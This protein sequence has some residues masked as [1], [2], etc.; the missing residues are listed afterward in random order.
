MHFE[1]D[2]LILIG[3]AALGTGTSLAVLIWHAHKGRPITLFAT[4]IALIVLEWGGGL[5]KSA[6]GESSLQLPDCW[7][8]L[9]V[10]LASLGPF[11]AGYIV[12]AVMLHWRSGPLAAREIAE[13]LHDRVDR[14]V[15]ARLWVL[16][17]AL[18]LCTLY[19]LYVKVRLA[20]G[21]RAFFDIAYSIR[22]GTHG[23][24]G[25]E[26]MMIVAAGLLAG[27]VMAVI[28]LLTMVAAGSTRLSLRFWLLLG[29]AI[30]LN[31]AISAMHGRR[32][33]V[34]I[35]TVIPLMAW[36]LQ[37]PIALRA[38]MRISCFLLLGLLCLN[39]LHYYRFSTTADW[40]PTS[41]TESSMMLLTPQEH[42]ET[43]AE[44]LN[45]AEHSQLL[46]A[47]QYAHST[48]SLV[49]RALWLD[50]PEHL[51]SLAVQGWA[52]LPTHFQ[53]SVTDVGEAVACMGY[54]GMAA[55]AIWGILYSMLDCLMYSSAIGRAVVVGICIT[56]VCVDQ[57]MGVSALS[58]S[59]ICAAI[60]TLLLWV[61]VPRRL[62]SPV[63]PSVN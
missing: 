32:V 45:T 5:I 4:Y 49:P 14:S 48:A 8:P 33:G 34:I 17:A 29:A 60:A 9:I 63:A 22:F 1:S 3:L 38:L 44:V 23:E 35:V 59:M 39:W 25:P 11:C 2:F 57:G 43:L 51:G 47:T 37:R 58:N 7:R 52:G 40:E 21:L 12:I 42:L 41:F 20:G 30:A 27:P 6:L 10:R 62:T 16:W 46:G 28:T 15:V 50:K 53:M 19:P 36:H 55:L 31:L 26:N 13:E 61:V 54:A 24:T 18:A 56:R